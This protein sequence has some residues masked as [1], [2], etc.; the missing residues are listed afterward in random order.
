MA[1]N[2]LSERAIEAEAQQHEEGVCPPPPVI[3]TPPWPDE[4][5]PV[6]FDD[7]NTTAIEELQHKL[8]MLDRQKATLA[9]EP[10]QARS[11]PLATPHHLLPGMT[12]DPTVRIRHPQ[13]D[14]NLALQDHVCD[15]G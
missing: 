9:D 10:V 3:R 8:A 11:A 7:G 15:G 4:D 13:L 14:L 6:G 5:L 12:L 2:P 1:V